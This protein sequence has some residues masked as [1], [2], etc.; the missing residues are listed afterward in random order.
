MVSLYEYEFAHINPINE[1]DTVN[2]TKGFFLYLFE[3]D[4]QEK[5]RVVYFVS[6]QYSPTLY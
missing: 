4:E 5:M 3:Y 6:K 1:I 2:L